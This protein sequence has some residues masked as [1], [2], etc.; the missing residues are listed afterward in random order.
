MYSVKYDISTYVRIYPVCSAY[1]SPEAY[2]S[3]KERLTNESRHFVTAS[4][5]FVK[6]ATESEGK[7]LECL[8]HCV[9]RIDRIGQVTREVAEHAPPENA[10]ATEE[11]VG[12]VRDVAETYLLTVRAAGDAVGKRMNDPSMNVLMKR[13]TSLASVLTTLMRSLRVF[14]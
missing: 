14:A 2:S 1:R 11:L 13:A 12:K 8:S 9:Q 4:K 6:S 7:L 10:P 3:A 5:L